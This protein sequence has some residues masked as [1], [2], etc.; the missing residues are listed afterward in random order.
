MKEDGDGSS[1]MV[2]LCGLIWAR[3]L[4]L[5]EEVHRL[6]SVCERGWQVYRMGQRTVIEIK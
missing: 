1:G 4:F 5:D 3:G 6:Y 2:C